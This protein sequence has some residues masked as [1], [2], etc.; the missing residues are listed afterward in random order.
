RRVATVRPR[1]EVALRPTA[2]GEQGRRALT[3][4]LDA[5]HPRARLDGVL[6]ERIAERLHQVRTPDAVARASEAALQV[7]QPTAQD[8]AVPAL[9]PVVPERGSASRHL[10]RQAEPLQGAHRVGPPGQPGSD[11]AQLRRRLAGPTP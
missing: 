11:L 6:A 10:L 4:E 7:H 2:A 8:L 9:D 1:Q 5:G 3:G